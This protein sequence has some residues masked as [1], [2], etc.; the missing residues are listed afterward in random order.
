MTSLNCL[1]KQTDCGRTAAEP[2]CSKC[3]LDERMRYIGEDAALLA[4]SQAEARYWKN[5]AESVE[6]EALARSKADEVK[7]Q[8][9]KEHQEAQ[10]RKNHAESIELEALACRKAEEVK[11]QIEREHQETQ[12]RKAEEDKE[13]ERRKSEEAKLK[14]EK[15]KQ[16]HKEHARKATE[17][18][19]QL[20]SKRALSM[21]YNLYR[22]HENELIAEKERQEAY[23]NMLA[24][25][26][27]REAIERRELEK[28]KSEEVRLQAEKRLKKHLL[29]RQKKLP[30]A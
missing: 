28:L 30:N 9:E 5:H 22:E 4:K 3:S 15:E 17:M 19:A 10:A 1:I 29:K 18:I 25:V 14:K 13:I 7:R 12:T 23:A 27:K 2:I 16:F 24:E 20:A 26:A 21:H 8:A 11:R 6:R